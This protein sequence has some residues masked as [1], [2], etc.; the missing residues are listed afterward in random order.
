MLDR[1]L[2]VSLHLELQPLVESIKV[3]RRVRQSQS[4]HLGDIKIP[5]ILLVQ[6]SNI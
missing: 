6:P 4:K 5:R 1:W 3:F 2:G